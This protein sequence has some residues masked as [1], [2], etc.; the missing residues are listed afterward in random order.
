MNYIST[1]NKKHTARR[2]WEFQESYY[3]ICE[4]ARFKSLPRSTWLMIVNKE[5]P[6]GIEAK[7]TGEV[8]EKSDFFKIDLME[9]EKMPYFMQL[10]E[11]EHFNFRCEKYGNNS[12]LTWKKASKYEI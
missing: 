12:G 3:K 4:Q 7:L 6:E 1:K 2:F 5:A 8:V 11:E 10:S 9:K